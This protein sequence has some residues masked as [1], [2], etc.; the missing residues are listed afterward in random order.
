MI[1]NL[2]VQNFKSIKDVSI[3]LGRLN[4]LVGPNMSGKSNLI[5]VFRFL[6]RMISPPHPSYG[7]PSAHWMWAM[8]FKK[9]FG[10]AAIPI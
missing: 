4:V 3:D 6:S 7:L 8:D 2:H 10:R 9:R 5:D 1:R